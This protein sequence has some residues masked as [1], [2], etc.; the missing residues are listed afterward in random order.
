MNQQLV[1]WE[2]APVNLVLSA[3]NVH[4]WYTRLEQPLALVERLHDSLVDDERTRAAR[5][6]FDRD[7]RNF[8]VARGVL[9]DILGAYLNCAPR[10][11][12]IIY[13]RA[14]KPSLTFSNP[15]SLE[16]NLSHSHGLAIY[17]LAQ[18]QVGIDV[19][20]IRPLADRDRIVAQNFSP[21]ERAVFATLSS[22]K[23]DVAFYHTWTRKE[24]F[25]KAIGD[26]LTYPLDQFSVLF[27]ADAP[28][29]FISVAHSPQEDAR[30]WVSSFVPEPNY[31]AA[32]AT[33]GAPMHISFWSWQTSLVS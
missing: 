13:G 5:F 6:V 2:R 4:V 27:D 8:I 12:Q 21:P 9:R 19:E 3:N 18:R 22:R 26:G 29:G 32:C 25:I 1:R 28:A 7:R 14:G 11:I 17:A 31:I 30:W 24:A 23:K 33:S 10:D 20:F 15:V 16:F